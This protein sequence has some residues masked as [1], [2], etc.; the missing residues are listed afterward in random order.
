MHAT[1]KPQME[2]EAALLQITCSHRI[3][4]KKN[5]SEKNID[6]D[7]IAKLQ[8]LFL[9]SEVFRYLCSILGSLQ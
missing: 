2:A 3:Q 4:V 6:K 7:I 1:T 5:K 9:I 8:N